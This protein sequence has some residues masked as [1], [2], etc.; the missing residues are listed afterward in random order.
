MG[1]G[2]IGLDF[3]GLLVLLNGFGGLSALNQG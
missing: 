2:Q 1:L 3:Q